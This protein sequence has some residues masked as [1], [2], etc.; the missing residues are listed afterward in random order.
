M[1]QETILKDNSIK[2]ISENLSKF[3]ADF[4]IMKYAAK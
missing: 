1:Q 2:I 3:L 4:F